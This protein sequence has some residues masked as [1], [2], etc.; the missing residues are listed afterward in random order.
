MRLAPLSLFFCRTH[1]KRVPTHT[2][3]QQQET[4]TN[5]RCARDCAPFYAQH[6][7]APTKK[8]RFDIHNNNPAL[9]TKLA[10]SC[11]AARALCVF[12]FPARRG[13]STADFRLRFLRSP[14]RSVDGDGGGAAAGKQQAKARAQRTA[15]A[16]ASHEQQPFLQK[17]VSLNAHGC[18]HHAFA[19]ARSLPSRACPLRV[20]SACLA[21]TQQKQWQR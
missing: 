12:V 2:S 9:A 7:A 1:N 19:R 5:S 21:H 13:A 17:R 20:P 6:A 15:S 4:R 11:K 16:H 10:R 14:L 3:T 8:N 18:T